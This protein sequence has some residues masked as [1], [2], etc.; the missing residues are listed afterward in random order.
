MIKKI[1]VKKE[2]I[3]KKSQ[4]IGAD[5]ILVERVI[6][7][8]E[9]LSFLVKGKIPLIFKGGTSLMLLMPE[10]RRLSIDIDIVIGA[11]DTTLKNAFNAL[12]GTTSIKLKRSFWQ[13]T[14]TS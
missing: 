9:L 14:I 3:R 1:C 13:I 11:E 8:F 4:E 5:P 2:F 10:L 7:A 12:T 6:F